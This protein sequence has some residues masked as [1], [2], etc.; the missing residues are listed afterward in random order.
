[1]AYTGLLNSLSLSSLAMHGHYHYIISMN[2]T[3][4]DKSS[5]TSLLLGHSPLICSQWHVLFHLQEWFH[6]GT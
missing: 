4:S 6:A 3:D 5:L 2:I 1:M